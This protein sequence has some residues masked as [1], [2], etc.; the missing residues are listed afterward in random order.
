MFCQNLN[1]YNLI[2]QLSIAKKIFR[3]DG[4][5][6]VIDTMVS[7]QAENGYCTKKKVTL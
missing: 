5:G 1:K 6:T 2:H 4:I 3:W 7:L